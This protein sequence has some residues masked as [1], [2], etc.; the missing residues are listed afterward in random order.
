[1]QVADRTDKEITQL[2]ILA[3]QYPIDVLYFANSMGSLNLQ[4]VRAITQAFKK[5]IYVHAP[6]KGHS[7]DEKN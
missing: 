5:Q 7:K 4:Q 3:N 6:N 2:A 1:M